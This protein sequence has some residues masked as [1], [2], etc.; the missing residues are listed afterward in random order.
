MGTHLP[1]LS[2]HVLNRLRLGKMLAQRAVGGG[3]LGREVRVGLGVKGYSFGHRSGS[4]GYSV[5]A[6]GTWGGNLG[7][8]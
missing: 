8:V 6:K 3:D 7:Q 1:L 2:L 5:R 4:E